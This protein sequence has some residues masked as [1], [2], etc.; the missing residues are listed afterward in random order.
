M[1]SNAFL[2]LQG[3]KNLLLLLLVHNHSSNTP[4]RQ[5]AWE[6]AAHLL[7]VRVTMDW[8]K[9]CEII[10]A[11]EEVLNADPRVPLRR[12][13]STLTHISERPGET[14]LLKILEI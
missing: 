10:Y 2:V 7:R 4:P 3:A 9:G 8:K 14:L 11:T 6:K 5:A 1:I 13:D 12:R